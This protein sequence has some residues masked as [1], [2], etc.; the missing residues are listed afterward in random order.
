VAPHSWQGWE[1]Y[2]V[3][4][5]VPVPPHR[6]QRP[7]PEQNEQTCIAVAKSVPSPRTGPAREVVCNVCLS[8]HRPIH[9]PGASRLSPLNPR[10]TA[11][12]FL[13][14]PLTVAS[15]MGRLARTHTARAYS[16]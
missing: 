3:V 6:W 14:S 2:R 16:A 12:I 9:N 11:R 8:V 13:V 5:K 1:R 10:Q 4:R 7:E 15:W